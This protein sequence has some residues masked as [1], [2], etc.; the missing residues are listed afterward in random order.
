MPVHLSAL[1]AERSLKPQKGLVLSPDGT[2]YFQRRLVSSF[3]I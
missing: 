1:D 2:G 3:E